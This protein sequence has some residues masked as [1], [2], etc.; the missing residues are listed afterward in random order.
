MPIIEAIKREILNPFIYLLFGAALVVFI[1]GI[2]QF[3]GKAD[4]QAS[5]DTGKNH[6]KWGIIGMF[7]MVAAWGY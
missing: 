5:R 2:V 7:I 6:M 1:W 3:V 4:E